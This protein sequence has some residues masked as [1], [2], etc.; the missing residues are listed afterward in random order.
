MG[1][2]GYGLAYARPLGPNMMSVHRVAYLLAHPGKPAPAMV[3]HSCDT[4]LCV[5]ALHLFAGDQAS[6]MADM[7]AKG[8]AAGG[9]KGGVWLKVSARQGHDM[10]RMRAAGMSVRALGVLFGLTPPGV[11]YR[12]KLVAEGRDVRVRT[13]YLGK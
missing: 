4:P 5:N 9:R 3:L 8:R 12:L 10:A 7:K 1:R 6:N 11:R 13:H 2:D